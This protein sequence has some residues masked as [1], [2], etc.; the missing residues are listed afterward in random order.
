MGQSIELMGMCDESEGSGCGSLGSGSFW[1]LGHSVHLPI[2]KSHGDETLEL[3]VAIYL[4]APRCDADAPHC[5]PGSLRFPT[6]WPM[7]RFSCTPAPLYIFS[8][9]APH[10]TTSRNRIFLPHIYHMA[11]CW[12]IS[13]SAVSEQYLE[14][15]S[16]NRWSDETTSTCAT[17]AILCIK[18]L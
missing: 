5:A 17:D 16:Q 10:Q 2:L 15:N 6:H 11:F 1:K 9:N 8:R 4:Q 14:G 3:V 18:L 7:R 12:Y 13:S